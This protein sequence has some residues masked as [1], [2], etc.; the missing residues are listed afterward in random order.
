MTGVDP[1]ATTAA[2]RGRLR[3]LGWPA[4][5]FATVTLVYVAYSAWQWSRLTVKSW[6]LGIFTQLLQHYAALQPP[7]V[8][9]KGDGYNLLG[10]HFHPLLVVFA[11]I[12]AVFPHAF[13][14]LV[15]QAACFGV[16]AA[17][18]TWAARR[19]LGA[20][21]GIGVG[22]AFGFSWGLQY[23]VEAQFHEIALAVPLLTAGLVMF[24][25]CRW[26]AAMIATGL[27]VFVKEDLGLTVATVGAILWVRTR[28]W[29]GPAL[30]AW[31][32]G[33]FVLTTF[34]ILP[35]LNPNHRWG[36]SD[37]LSLG[38]ADPANLFDPAK[39][40]TVLLLVAAMAI[41]GLRS[42]I[43]LVLVP[44]LAW[45]FA[46]TNEGYWK[47]DWHYSAVLMPIVFLALIDGIRLARRS[48]HPFVFKLGSHAPAIAITVA[49]M[50]FPS[51]PV[52]QLWQPD[53]FAPVS[54]AAAARAALAAVPA[55][56]SVES[57][58]GLMNSLVDDH[59]VTWIG[60]A[61]PEPDCVLIDRIAGGTPAD[62][63]EVLDVAQHLHPGASFALR[64]SQDGYQLA[65]R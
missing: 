3:G 43:A 5:V 56:A 8:P 62:W 13:T 15:I 27:L 60:N 35:A 61:N 14:L 10:D 11:P 54:R 36:Y 16:A 9:I 65:C 19:H 50:V 28:D 58:I 20:G 4:A 12:F 46:S 7:I 41:I 57:D 45:R 59:Q 26:T 6:D 30:A 31:G 40:S 2:L 42:P 47:P 25:E 63:G 34:V 33:W 55:G 32:V 49:V 39:V 51:L 38:V 23:A 53:A 21:I 52:A 1:R 29:R 18:V 24:I 44:T 37:S 48:P 22:L 64:F 17:L